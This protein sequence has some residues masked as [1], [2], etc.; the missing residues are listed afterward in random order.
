MDILSTP[1]V[2][3]RNFTIHASSGLGS[4]KG[5]DPS[6]VLNPTQRH[7]L[8]ILAT[9]TSS[10]SLA[11]ALVAAFWFLMMQRNFRRDLVLLLILGGS[12]KSLWFV[13]FSGVTFATGPIHT[14]D[15]ICQVGGY[16]LQA[17]FEACDIAVFFMS[18]HMYY[19]IFPPSNSMLG[20]DGLY[21]IRYVVIIAYILFP[22][23]SAALGF[24]SN[25]SAYVAQGAWCSLPL[26]P[27]WYRLG[28]FWVPRYIVWLYIVFVAIR[29]Y[30]YVGSEFK[31]FGGE[32]ASS[33]SYGLGGESSGDRAARVE[34]E[35]T[36]TRRRS[37]PDVAPLEE[38]GQPEPVNDITLA[39]NPSLPH[40][41]PPDVFVTPPPSPS[42]RANQESPHRRSP[43]RTATHGPVSSTYPASALRKE[44]HP[45]TV[46]EDFAAPDPNHRRSS[47]VSFASQRS[48]GRESF[49]GPPVLSPI[50]ESDD[51]LAP[52]APKPRS[53]P[54]THNAMRNRRRAIQRQ[55][56]LLFI[57]P[58]VY[59]LLWVIPFVVNI[60]N[61]TNRY[62]Q[63]PVFALQVLQIFTLT[64]MTLADV[65]VFSWRERPWR[66]I[67]GADGTFLGSFKWW[68][69][70]FDKKWATGRRASRV[71]SAIPRAANSS[72]ATTSTTNTTITD[73]EKGTA[74]AAAAAGLLT[75]LRSSLH[76][77]SSSFR[78]VSARS[79]SSTAAAS[80]ASHPTTP[81][82]RIVFSG[83]HSDRR[84]L[85]VQRAHERLALERAEY[86][87]RL[88]GVREDQDGVEGEGRGRGREWFDRQY[89]DLFADKDEE[90]GAD[91]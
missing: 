35:L 42:R 55:L 84:L 39:F 87:G 63:H 34:K 43:T 46:T 76:R 24:T 79:P 59:L 64:I 52:A 75:P 36:S 8:Q 80:L 44:S 29:I 31:V 4:S 81:Q 23:L 56:R 73:P 11:A 15:T 17:G 70:C 10:L 25:T 54:A 21:R 66:H 38:A 82:K 18:M 2:G 45:A 85:E 58:V 49:D 83:G 77:K 12:W 14:S 37:D 89:G 1:H 40:A 22:N 65:V 88:R 68:Q 27:F 13:I 16:C 71:P 7:V 78:S 62:A 6:D 47:L 53:R 72:A 20:H 69:Y 86:E 60:M 3:L 5:F 41:F 74:P 26:R 67:P 51:P 91:V 28:L 9:V 61:F 48:S 30:R 19:Q 50:V 57:Y 33:L 32:T 90:E